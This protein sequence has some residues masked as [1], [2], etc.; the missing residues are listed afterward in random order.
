MLC[1]GRGNVSVTANLAPRLMH[2]LCM[3]AINGD[4]AGAMAIQR[5]LMPLHRELFV[6]PNPI[7]LKWAMARLG[8]CGGT[9]R[10]P[11]TPLTPAAQPLVE[12]ALRAAGLLA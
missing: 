12:A 7:P 4:A 10:P 11:M 6:E 3:A 8:L 2:Q 5:K 9:L 1:G